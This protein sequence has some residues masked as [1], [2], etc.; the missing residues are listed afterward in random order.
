MSSGDRSMSHPYL[1][2]SGS[3]E[4]AAIDRAVRELAENRDLVETTEHEY[5]VG[6]LCQALARTT[7]DLESPATSELEA[8]KRVR[9]S[10]KEANSEGRDLVEELLAER[11]AEARRG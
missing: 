1:R 7:S 5:V 8:L 4:W 2:F 9:L 10:V 6:Y 11:T 3:P